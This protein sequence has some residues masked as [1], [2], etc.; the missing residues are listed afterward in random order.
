MKAQ[1]TR[2]KDQKSFSIPQASLIFA[3]PK[4]RNIALCLAS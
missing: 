2:N 1:E 3:A 4:S